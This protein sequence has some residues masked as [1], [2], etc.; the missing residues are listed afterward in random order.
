ME[1]KKL[2]AI[3]L[4]LPQFHPIP[5]NDKYWGKGF[6]E[7]TNVAKA[8]PLFRGHEQPRIPMDTGFYDLRLPETRALQAKLAKEAGIEGFCYW[9]YWFG[10]G[11]EVLQMPFDEVVKSGEPDFPFCLGWALHDWSTKTWEKGDRFAK[12]V[13]IF[14]Q[15][16]PGSED[17]KKHFYRLLPAFRDSRYITVDD[18]L[19]FL[20]LVPEKLPNPKQFM[21]HWNRLA[22]ENGLKGFHFVAGI[23][24]LDSVIAE[25]MNEIHQKIDKKIDSFIEQGF[26]AVE[27]VNNKYAEIKT[28]GRGSKLV[29]GLIRKVW[30]ELILDTFSYKKV[31][32]NWFTP[33][34]SRED[35]Y[36]QVLVGWDRSPRAGRKAIIYYHDTPEAF[37]K[38][39]DT[40]LEVVAN[41]QPEHRIVF[42]NSW[43]EWGEGAYLEPDNRYGN[44]KLQELRKRLND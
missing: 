36:P 35:V 30:P 26:D 22:K 37:G 44:R 2:R 41:K 39:M 16:F 17:E 12:D 11:K 21:D 13:T 23:Q 27:L 32:E 10:N 28:K 8:K 3:A 4:Y 19:L 43:N 24:A 20:I 31:M 18:R 5:E 42:L 1:E 29:H 15:L 33:S 34:D 14:K 25:S 9:H 6:T 7:W 38:V 40:A